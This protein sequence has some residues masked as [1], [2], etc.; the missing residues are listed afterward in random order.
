MLNIIIKIATSNT[1]QGI[2]N[3]VSLIMGICVSVLTL[4]TAYLRF[5]SKNIRF[6]TYSPHFSTFYG[7][8]LS[9]VIENQSL[10]TFSIQ[11]IYLVYDCKYMI[12]IEKFDEPLILEPFKA[13]K[14]TSK[15]ITLT[16]PLSL[17]EL[18]KHR[19]I[20]LMI[21][22]S[23]GIIYSPMIGGRIK[24]QTKNFDAFQLVSKHSE[25]INGTVV[26][27]GIQYILYYKGSNEELKTVFIDWAGFMSETISNFNAI[28]RDIVNNKEK[29]MQIFEKIFNPLNIP[30]SL[31]ERKVIK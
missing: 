12:Q 27:N 23:K 2:L 3:T 15:P 30:F 4:Y 17:S 7:D 31:E 20:F 29:V 10:S 16:S 1:F 6:L 14:I 26:S 19:N 9:V 24:K 22:T 5:I 11:E 21:R 18:D 25:S 13:K 8:K 28:P